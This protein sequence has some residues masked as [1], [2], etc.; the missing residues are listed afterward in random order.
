[1]KTDVLELSSN[2][3]QFCGTDD[4][5]QSSIFHKSFYHTDGIQ[6]LAE[7]AGAFWLIDAIVSHQTKRNV[8]S[9]GLQVWTLS[10]GA[11]KSAILKCTD[12]DKGDGEIVLARQS[13]PYTDF[14]ME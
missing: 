9:E 10:V 5:H 8:R 1:M 12:G 6:Y 13:I 3:A 11:K 14:Q 7:K 4:Y 2:L